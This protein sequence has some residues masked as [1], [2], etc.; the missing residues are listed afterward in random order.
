MTKLTFYVIYIGMI[1]ICSSKSNKNTYVL[2][3]GIN[4]NWINDDKLYRRHNQN[5]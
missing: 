2:L 5:P 3:D 4:L 1:Y